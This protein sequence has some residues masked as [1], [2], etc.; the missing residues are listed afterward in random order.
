[1]K[2]IWFGVVTTFFGP[3]IDMH[4]LLKVPKS[5][6]KVRHRMHVIYQKKFDMLVCNKRV[7]QFG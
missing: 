6:Q 2:G 7:P 4:H 1:M 5:K 3:P